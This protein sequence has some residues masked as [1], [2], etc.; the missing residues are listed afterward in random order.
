MVGDQR[1]ARWGGGPIVCPT[2]SP[3]HIHFRL[4]RLYGGQWNAKLPSIC[5]FDSCGMD[6]LH[7]SCRMSGRKPSFMWVGVGVR[8]SPQGLQGR[9]GAGLRSILDAK[10][11]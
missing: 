11:K 7:K 8:S 3:K 2:Y 4:S 5:L 10:N 6:D 1:N 9:G